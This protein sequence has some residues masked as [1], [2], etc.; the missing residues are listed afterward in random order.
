MV[1]ELTGSYQVVTCDNDIFLLDPQR[2]VGQGGVEQGLRL[3]V[4]AID[5]EVKN[6]SRMIVVFRQVDKG[7]FDNSLISKSS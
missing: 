5:V 1:T 3:S 7:H 2:F 6:R 4:E